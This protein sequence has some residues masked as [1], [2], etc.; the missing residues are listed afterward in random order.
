MEISYH[1]RLGDFV[2]YYEAYWEPS[3]SASRR[4]FYRSAVWYLLIL[5]FAAFVAF[6]NEEVFA[7]CVFV[8]LAGYFVRGGLGFST[9]WHDMVRRHAGMH[10][11]ERS[12]LRIDG[13]GVRE[14]SPGFE[15]LVEW[16]F[17]EG[18]VETDRVVCL[19][20]LRGG[21]FVVPVRELGEDGKSRFTA[22]LEARGVRRLG[23]FPVAEAPTAVVA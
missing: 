2:A 23:A 19:C 7:G 11:E 22:E 17:V 20:V 1:N 4:S 3:K 5:A 6:R 21:C 8:A 16:A 10:R 15:T 14:T 9:R 12:V 13:R 18:Y